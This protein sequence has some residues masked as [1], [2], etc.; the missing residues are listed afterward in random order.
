MQTTVWPSLMMHAIQ[1]SMPR[2]KDW[3]PY[4]EE[5]K[6]HRERDLILRIVP[7]LYNFRLEF[8]GLNQIWST[9]VLSWSKDADYYIK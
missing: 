7:L 9:Y 6:A 8:V 5:E 1:C 3:F 4:E 2:L